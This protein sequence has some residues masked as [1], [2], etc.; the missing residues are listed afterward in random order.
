MERL[1]RE[2]APIV[3]GI[4]CSN[5]HHRKQSWSPIFMTDTIL[6]TGNTVTVGTEE[7][8]RQLSEKDINFLKSGAFSKV[9]LTL[10]ET[11]GRKQANDSAQV[12]RGLCR[13]GV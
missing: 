1:G 5:N 10:E 3:E 7:V 4:G 13:E 9:D 6:A 12:C 2:Y 8:V 11:G